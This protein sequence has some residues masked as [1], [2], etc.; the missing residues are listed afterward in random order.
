MA[1]NRARN[2]GNWT[3][4]SNWRDSFTAKVGLIDDPEKD[5]QHRGDAEDCNHRV[6]WDER[7]VYRVHG[8][9]RS[10]GKLRR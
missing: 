2:I 9:K 8:A 7:P 6:D 4:P 5:Q 1:A 10:H 3:V